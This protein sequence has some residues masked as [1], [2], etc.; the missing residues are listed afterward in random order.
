MRCALAHDYLGFVHDELAGR[1]TPP[2]PPTL[3]LANVV[4]S[5]TERDPTAELAERASAW[6]RRLVERRGSAGLTIIGPAP[7]PVERIKQRWRWHFLIKAQRPA[8]LT[9]VGRYF[10]EKFPV[11]KRAGLRVAFDRDPV[12]LL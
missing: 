12:A 7:C 2:Y 3:R 10:M 5:G 9:R 6:V 1:V 4:L 11:P 8:E